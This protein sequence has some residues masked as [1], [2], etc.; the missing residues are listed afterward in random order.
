MKKLSH[1]LLPC[2]G[3]TLALSSCG[4]YSR[5]QRPTGITTE[6]Y[7]TDQAVLASADSS[8]SLGRLPWRGLF[9]DP[10]LQQ[11]IEEALRQNVD[12]QT[13]ALSVRQAEAQ[14]KAARLS[15]FPSLSLAPSVSTRKS[16]GADAMHSYELPV[17]AS[18]QVDLFGA[19]LNASRSTQV[20][21]L[22]AQEYQRLVQSR[23]IASVANGYYTLLML[24]RQLALS[25]EAAGLAQRTLEVMQAQKEH[26]RALESAVQSARAAH[27]QV[28]ASLPEIKR[29]RIA[30]E[31][32]LALLLGQSPRSYERSTLEAQRL[33]EQ[34]SVGL[35]VQLLSQRPDVRVAELALASCYYQTNAARSALY[36]TLS[37][38]G[39]LGWVGSLGQAV[40][41]P[42]RLVSSA[43]G[44]LAQP[45]FARGRLLA[46]LRVAQ[47]E[48]EKAL[49]AFQQSLL[50][51]GAEVSNALAL[52]EASTERVAEEAKQIESLKANVAITEELFRSGRS[53]SYLEVISAQQSL[54]QAQLTE[55]R[56]RFSRMQA[57]V[58]LYNALG[59]G[60]DTVKP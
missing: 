55:V 23:L 54:L 34:L 17:Q 44:A 32:S 48:Q 14:L 25:Q 20:Q 28:Q 45:I 56:D 27:H 36:P 1:S 16:E 52:Y 51:A 8:T 37:I 40:A 30:A 29:Q 4:I 41:N 12:L 9:T 2:L 15:F 46:G 38:S 10:Q 42:M 53:S 6:V 19:L 13:A 31:N 47:A 3:L 11:L 43:V 49:L 24:D 5:Y 26:G 21:L 50:S 58:N 39:S 35:P 18:W 33:P 57:V 7:R 22:R 59:G 60:A